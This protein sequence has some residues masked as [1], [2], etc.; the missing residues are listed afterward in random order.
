MNMLIMESTKTTPL[1]IM[2]TD[3]DLVE[4]MKKYANGMNYVSS[5]VFDNWKNH[6]S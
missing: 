5:V 4:T 2:D 3:F 1:E 6:S